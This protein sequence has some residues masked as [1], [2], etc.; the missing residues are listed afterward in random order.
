[1]KSVKLD[2]LM[3]VEFKGRRKMTEKVGKKKGKPADYKA[4]KAKKL[5]EPP[6]RRPTPDRVY[7]T[8]NKLGELCGFDRSEDEARRLST[9]DGDS[10]F[11]Y[12]LLC[13]VE[14]N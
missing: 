11:E 1:M 9:F 7:V 3:P 12:Q 4:S 6:K 8:I 13:E 10:L 2:M 14:L 5:P